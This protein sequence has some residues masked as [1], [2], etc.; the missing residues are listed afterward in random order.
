M[1][2]AFVDI[3]TLKRQLQL[4]LSDPIKEKELKDNIMQLKNLA[5]QL[6]MTNTTTSWK[7]AAFKKL[8]TNNNYLTLDFTKTDV[9]VDQLAGQMYNLCQKILGILRG[10]AIDYAVYMEIDDKL[11]RVSMGHIPETAFH[12]S[13]SGVLKFN[14]KKSDF[15]SLIEKTPQQTQALLAEHYA[16]ML[17][18]LQNSYWYKR[19]SSI[20]N[21]YINQGV[22]AEAFEEHIK[23]EQIKDNPPEYQIQHTWSNIQAWGLVNGV[24]QDRTAWYVQGDVG[25]TQVKNLTSGAL[26][27]ASLSSLQDVVNY[28]ITLSDLN[29][30]NIAKKAEEIVSIMIVK[31]NIETKITQRIDKEIKRMVKTSLGQI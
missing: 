31:D 17:S 20:P 25:N 23:T 29:K 24:L 7:T 10:Q 19:K 27:V 14:L 9:N 18:T 28:L 6:S 2:N 4:I 1:A 30:K 8:G 26:R 13:S 3:E 5:N 21:R 22:I 16:Q 15:K 12:V 11:Q